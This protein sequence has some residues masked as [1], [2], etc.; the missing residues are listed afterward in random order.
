M[1]TWTSPKLPVPDLEPATISRADAVFTGVDHL[2]PSYEARVFVGNQRANVDTPLDPG[3][4]YAGSF[5]VF[6]HHGCFGEEGHCD[7]QRRYVDEFDLRQPHPME[8]VTKI[9]RITEALQ[10]VLPADDV[11][12]R[13]VAV[14]NG[15]TRSK[16]S[17]AMEFA[18]LRLLVYSD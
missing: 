12:I 11:V 9:V 8:P 6:G 16:P 1:K 4:G 17:D 5:T 15:G 3:R 13:V 18:E 10:R 2:G 14:D 7:P